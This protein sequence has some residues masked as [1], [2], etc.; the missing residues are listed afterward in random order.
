[1]TQRLT[2]TAAAIGKDSFAD[3]LRGEE[4]LD[5]GD[6]GDEGD[7]S[8]DDDDVET[9]PTG[10]GTSSSDK[11]TPELRVWKNGSSTKEKS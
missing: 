11:Y 3:F 2:K 1:M 4:G 5:K 6:K 7:A 9:G 10:G 8:S